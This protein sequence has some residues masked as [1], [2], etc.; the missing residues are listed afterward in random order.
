MVYD[1]KPVTDHFRKIDTD[2]LIGVVSMQGFDGHFFFQRDQVKV[3]SPSVSRCLADNSVG[4]ML[5]RRIRC[6]QPEIR[7]ENNMWQ[8]L[9]SAGR[10]AS[11]PAI[12]TNASSASIGGTKLRPI[13][14]FRALDQCFQQRLQHSY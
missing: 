9:P 7:Y 8:P 5:H 6:R 4:V 10:G 3:P 11:T 13:Q 14:F 2:R 1:S 12:T